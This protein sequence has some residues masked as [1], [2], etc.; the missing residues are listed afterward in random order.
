MRIP[1]DH[2]GRRKHL[3]NRWDRIVFLF[4][5]D[6]KDNCRRIHHGLLHWKTPSQQKYEGTLF[7]FR[8]VRNEV[9]NSHIALVCV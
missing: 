7:T 4:L 6:H 5:P 2:G 9:H 3:G 1:C 8:T